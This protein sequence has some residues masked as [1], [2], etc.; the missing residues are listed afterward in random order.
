MVLPA[1]EIL[2]S[3]AVTVTTDG[4]SLTITLTTAGTWL[5]LRLPD[6]S[7]SPIT[8]SPTCQCIG[9]GGQG[10]HALAVGWMAGIIVETAQ[11]LDAPWTPAARTH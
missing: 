4:Q 10:P 9:L 11:S 8:V 5:R 1:L 6:G 7:V 3:S 2:D